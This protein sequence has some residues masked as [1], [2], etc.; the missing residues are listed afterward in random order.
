MAGRGDC[1]LFIGALPIWLVEP[2]VA[3]STYP[4]FETTRFS[5]EA[6]R[7]AVSTVVIR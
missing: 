1:K 5:V 4:A 3:P 7:P 2:R 6:A